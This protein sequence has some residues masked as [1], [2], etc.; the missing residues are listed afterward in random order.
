MWRRVVRTI[1]ERE[2]TPPDVPDGMVAEMVQ[3]LAVRKN[4]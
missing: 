4:D 2:D 1:E 3:R